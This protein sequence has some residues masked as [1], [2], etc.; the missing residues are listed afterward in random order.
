MAKHT[1]TVLLSLRETASLLNVSRTTL[2][3]ITR[4]GN[5]PTVGI[6]TRRLVRED[7]LTAY[8]ERCRSEPKR[9]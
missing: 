1:E 8:I 3:R 4:D 2:W 7:D 6:G 5:L 9:H